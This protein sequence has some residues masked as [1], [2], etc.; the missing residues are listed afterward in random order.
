VR[1]AYRCLPIGSLGG[2]D[3]I[4]SEV[5][6]PHTTHDASARA[7]RTFIAPS[8]PRTNLKFE[9]RNPKQTNV[10]INPKS[11]KSK[12]RIEGNL[13]GIYIFWSFEFVSDFDIRILFSV[14]SEPFFLVAA[15]PHWVLWR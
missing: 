1:P 9:Y 4:T 3:K 14:F 12:T 10:Q 15:L 7:A 13:F 8:N 2:R 11:E 6:L 5:C